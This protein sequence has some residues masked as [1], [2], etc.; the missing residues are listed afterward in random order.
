MPVAVALLRGINVGGKNRLPMSA[1]RALCGRLGL[2]DVATCIQS[3]N[4]VF[5][6]GQPSLRNVAA[7]IEAAIEHDHGFRPCVVVRTADE[8]RA[9]VAANPFAG[10]RGLDPAKLLIMFTSAPTPASASNAIAAL[11]PDPEAVRLVGREV[12]L[13]YPLG[14]GASRFPFSR[15]EKAVGVPGTSR[16]L[17]TVLK[18][19]AMAEALEARTGPA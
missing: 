16:N 8:L 1:L 3:G 5:R 7:R 4:A 12:Y 13:H 9:A 17:K 2:T 11:R 15:V 10:L 6:V 14:I 19:L 18:L